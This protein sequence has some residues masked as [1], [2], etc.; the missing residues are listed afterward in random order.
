M[1][2]FE[3]VK[4]ILDDSVGG[5]DFPGHGAFWRGTDRDQFVAKVVFGFPLLTVG[6]GGGS[7]LIKALRGQAP[8][9][10]DIGTPG[11]FFNRMPD[12]RDPVKDTDIDFIQQWIDDGCPATD[13]MIAAITVDPG[14]GGPTDATVHNDFWRDFDNKALFQAEPE[15][16]AAINVF[17]SIGQ[18]WMSFARDPSK[19]AEWQAGVQGNSAAEAIRLLA[20]LTSDTVIAHY[21]NPVPL[22]TLL[23]SFERFGDNSLPNDPLRPQDPRHNMNGAIM[24]FFWSAFCDACLRLDIEPQYWRGHI[25]AL[26]LGLMNDGLFRGRFPVSGFTADDAGRQ[27]MRDHVRNLTDAEL[28]GELRKRFA[29]TSFGQ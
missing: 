7:N 16:S 2:R 12:G 24:W 6:N 27:A 8:F 4:Q 11:A 26:L 19:E 13:E 25:R 28:Q 22:L 29:D 23:D 18:R 21:G 14:G 15:V 9:G 20:K 3:K 17:F 5:E 10:A 1:N